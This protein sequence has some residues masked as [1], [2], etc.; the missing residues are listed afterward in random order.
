M[1]KLEDL[2][3]IV[4][5]DL[6]IVGGGI[7]GLVAAIKAKEECPNIDVLLVDKQTVGWAGKAPKIGGAITFVGP[8]D[9][10]DKFVEFCVRSLGIYLN[11]QELLERYAR[12]SYRSIEQI[13]EWGVRLVRDAEGKIAIKKF[14]FA[15]ELSGTGID[16]DMMLPLRGKARK[17][18]ARALNKIQVLRLLKK[19]EK[20][21]GAVG[22]NIVDGRFYIFKAKATILASG[23]CSFKNRRFWCSATGE[24]IA[25]AYWAGA[26]MRNAEFG[27]ACSHI[28]F[29]AT[30][31]A[32]V[33]PKY[34]VNALGES[35]YDRY[36]HDEVPPGFIVPFSFIFGMEKE[37]K[38]GRGPLYADLSKIPQDSLVFKPPWWTTGLPKYVEW[39]SRLNEKEQKYWR[40][41]S[42]KR[43]VEIPITCTISCVKVDHEMKTTL[44]G[45]WAIG[46]TSHTGSVVGG[47]RPCP[48][49]GG[50]GIGWAVLSAMWAGPSAAR[51][52]SEADSPEV[53]YEQVK[54]LK[55]DIF[56]PLKREKGVS[57]DDIVCALRD[58][59]CVTKYNLRRSED[60]LKEALSKVENARRR[61]T[62]L[63]AKDTHY[64][65]KCHEANAMTVCAE[66][67]L[68]SALMRNESRGFHY[69]E[70][71]PERD[72]KNWLKWI[73][74]KQVDGRM[75]L[76]TEPI[77]IGRYRFKPEG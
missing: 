52:A 74:I 13:T 17:L 21:V 26:E 20:V 62:D 39:W 25:A 54:Q 19:D 49:V 32:S 22:F 63:W 35:I 28:V 76:S 65:M 53:D 61:L 10:V 38:E 14:P 51:Y 37:V 68:R 12:E 43:E 31:S 24:G 77:P 66:M 64:L 55:E 56:S 50:F 36:V 11:D 45:L 60:R 70:D 44:P 58:V 41:T 46:E 59:M 69:R 5:T 71:Y 67:V 8:D 7:A 2:G 42:P 72:D 57:P 47:A 30:D 23:A 73:T 27:N 4:S 40:A 34:I 75:A 16:I 48:F 3:E 18:G 9:D 1:T 15:R 33:P 29:K 6:L